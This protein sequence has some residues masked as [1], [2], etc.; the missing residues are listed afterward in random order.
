MH[1]CRDLCSVWLGWLEWILEGMEWSIQPQ[2]KIVVWLDQ[3]N[4]M[5]HSF[6]HSI[7]QHYVTINSR[8]N[9]WDKPIPF[10]RL[11]QKIKNTL[12]VYT[13]AVLSLPL[14]RSQKVQCPTTPPISKSSVSDISTILLPFSTIF[15]PQSIKA[16]RF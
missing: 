1:K 8:W 10:S 15:K 2:K 16:Y 7:L 14:H 9:R 4:G 12:S 6:N 5:G 3:R 13:C 11:K